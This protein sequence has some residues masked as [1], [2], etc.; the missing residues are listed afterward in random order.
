MT[1]ISQSIHQSYHEHSETIKSIQRLDVNFT[2]FLQSMVYNKITSKA[3]KEMGFNNN[4]HY[5]RQHQDKTLEKLIPY[6]NAIKSLNSNELLALLRF[7][8]NK[9]SQ[10]IFE[11]LDRLNQTIYISDHSK[12]QH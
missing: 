9:N 10:T 4:S 2:Y 1:N 8:K 7:I 5:A 6:K 12:V 3:Q 11:L